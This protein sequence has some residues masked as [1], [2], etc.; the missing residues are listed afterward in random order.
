M[1]FNE[2]MKDQFKFQAYTE[3][4]RTVSQYSTLPLVLHNKDLIFASLK[5]HIGN[6]DEYALESLFDLCAAFAFDLQVQNI[7]SV[8]WLIRHENNITCSN[9]FSS[10]KIF[11]GVF[12]CKKAL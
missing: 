12:C 8:V 5:E 10:F 3:F 6:K 1:L 2:K 9:I 7:F 11:H 4:S